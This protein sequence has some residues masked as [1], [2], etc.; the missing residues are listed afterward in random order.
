MFYGQI[1][2]E[3]NNLPFLSS[4]IAVCLIL[5][6]I[7]KYPKSLMYDPSNPEKQKIELF[8]MQS[9]GF[10]LPLGIFPLT[11]TIEQVDL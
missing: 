8:L 1:S 3:S 6:G 4:T 7:V 11:S 10:L 2:L 9:P 5:D